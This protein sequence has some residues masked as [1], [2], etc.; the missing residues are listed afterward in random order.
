M[1]EST[2]QPERPRRPPAK[3]IPK[4]PG[5]Y[6]VPGMRKV[7][8]KRLTSSMQESPHF[9]LTGEIDMAPIAA[10]REKK[11]GEGTKLSFND[12]ILKAVGMALR[13]HPHV[14]AYFKG[15]EVEI[16]DKCNVGMAVALDDGLTVPVLREVDGKTLEQVSAES[17]ELAEKA[18]SGKLQLAELQGGGIT[19]SNLG[20]FDVDSFTAIINPPQSAI[21]AVGSIKKIPVVVEDRIEIGTR[22]KLTLSSDHRMVDGVLAAKFMMTIKELLQNPD[23]L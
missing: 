19:V 18:R 11:K 2:P 14:N 6:P 8:A 20:M 12:Y 22:M 5:T 23:R 16:L 7:I 4:E 3:T 10:H 9:Y 1:T 17:V 15:D 21:L 13:E